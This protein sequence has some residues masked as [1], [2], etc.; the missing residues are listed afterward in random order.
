MAKAIYFYHFKS[1]W[2]EKLNII[3]TSA[4][5]SPEQPNYMKKN[6]E[7]VKLK[8]ME[9]GTP[10]NG[11]NQSIFYYQLLSDKNPSSSVLKMV[12]YEGFIVF[13]I[14]SKASQSLDQT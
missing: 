10:K 13:A 9:F 3:N 5:F 7:Y 4:V 14:P 11:E 6:A 1:K 2:N 8:E 12:F